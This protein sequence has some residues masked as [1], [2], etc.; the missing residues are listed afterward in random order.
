MPRTNRVRW[1]SIACVLRPVYCVSGGGPCSV[2]IYRE[3][4]DVGPN[5]QE[6]RVAG[7]VDV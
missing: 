2:F 3:A 7:S 5:M 4:V 6:Q 1:A